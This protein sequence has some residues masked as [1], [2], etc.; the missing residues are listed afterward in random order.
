[1]VQNGTTALMQASDYG[2]LPVVEYLVQQGA[3]IHM[4]STVRNSISSMYYLDCLL[5]YYSC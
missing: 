2:R 4:Q 5:F 1:M 3:D